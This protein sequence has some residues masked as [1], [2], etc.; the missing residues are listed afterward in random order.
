MCA[1]FRMPSCILE[2]LKE[3]SS[4]KEQLEKQKPGQLKASILSTLL[5]DACK[6]LT[7][8]KQI[9]AQAKKALKV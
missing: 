8:A 2:A 9:K 5:P 7:S 1:P 6:A 3:A 4:I